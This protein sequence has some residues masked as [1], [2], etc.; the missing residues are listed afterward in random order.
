[1]LLPTGYRAVGW[2]SIAYALLMGLFVVFGLAIT[3][4]VPAPQDFLD[5][6]AAAVF[7]I[8]PLGLLLGGCLL[9]SNNPPTL[10]AASLVLIATGVVLFL[11]AA[12][13]TATTVREL[14]RPNSSTSVLVIVN[15]PLLIMPASIWAVTIL[16]TGFLVRRRLRQQPDPCQKARPLPPT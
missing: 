2:L 15:V 1:M 12:V 4:I 5:W 13:V 8:S 3:P 6:L 10:G 7:V 14:R 16:G 11:K 9:L